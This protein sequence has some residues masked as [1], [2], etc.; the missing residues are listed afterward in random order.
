MRD[1][2]NPQFLLDV[3]SQNSFQSVHQYALTLS[4]PRPSFKTGDTNAPHLKTSNRPNEQRRQH[5][6]LNLDQIKD[7]KGG[8][9]TCS[10][11]EAFSTT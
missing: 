5:D 10:W 7:F 8:L 1:R 3:H 2:L 6:F 9:D 11:L 4:S